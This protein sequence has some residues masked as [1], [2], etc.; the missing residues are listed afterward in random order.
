MTIEEVAN[1]TCEEL[2]EYVVSQEFYGNNRELL[3][4]YTEKLQTLLNDIQSA[5]DFYSNP[6]H[7]CFDNVAAAAY[8][9]MLS[10]L[11]S[12]MADAEVAAKNLDK[13]VK[14]CNDC[15]C[16]ED[17]FPVCANEMRELV[18]KYLTSTAYTHNNAI[19]WFYFRARV[20][21]DSFSRK[22]MGGALKDIY[23]EESNQDP[24]CL[25]NKR[26]LVA[27]MYGT[28]GIMEK[29]EKFRD[30]LRNVHDAGVAGLLHFCNA[31]NTSCATSYCQIVA[32][33]NS[34][35]KAF[36]DQWTEDV[37]EIQGLIE[38]I[39]CTQTNWKSAMSDAVLAST[40]LIA[41]LDRELAAD[42]SGVELAWAQLQEGACKMPSGA[43]T[44]V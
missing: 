9:K 16:P 17:H 29:I 37:Q 19:D 5:Y 25:V 32:N 28:D 7:A 6:K 3:R 12:A 34:V 30:R 41:D 43:P 38:L 10:T 44:K 24:L 11:R 8:A 4:E 31:G 36:R 21:K 42:V 1:A 2:K 33:A 39:D 22:C 40:K 23:P 13:I 35:S 27:M 15:E 20:L 18:L 14:I 26:Y